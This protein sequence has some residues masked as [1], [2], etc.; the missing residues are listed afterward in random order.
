MTYAIKIT[1]NDGDHWEAVRWEEW[2]TLA[3]A[4]KRA[5]HLRK[6]G[7]RVEIYKII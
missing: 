7:A 4:E 3:L 1:H 5:I 2:D 6:Q